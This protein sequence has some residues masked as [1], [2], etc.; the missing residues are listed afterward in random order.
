MKS[1]DITKE[2]TAIFR[3]LQAAVVFRFR[4]KTKFETDTTSIIV[5]YLYHFRNVNKEL[6][7]YC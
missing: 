2:V 4:E 6:F 7:G 1:C 5:S 3:K